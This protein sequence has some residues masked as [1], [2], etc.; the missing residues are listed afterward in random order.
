MA[1]Q[2]Q[3]LIQM[4]DL[5]WKDRNIRWCVEMLVPVWHSPGWG[6]HLCRGLASSQSRLC[7]HLPSS[8]EGWIPSQQP[9]VHPGG[10]QGECWG[11]WQYSKV[12]FRCGCFF[13]SVCL[14][15]SVFCYILCK[16]RPSLS[17]HLDHWIHLLPE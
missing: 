5:G 2:M 16:L 12:W 6:T 4:L 15:L 1:T 10:T 8:R 17:V 11:K 9:D 3:N 7:H 14:F 13:F